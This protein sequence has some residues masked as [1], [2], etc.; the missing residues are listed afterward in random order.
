[1][2]KVKA[3]VDVLQA[4]RERRSIRSYAAQKV[5]R[6]SVEALLAAAVRAPTAV[7]EEPWAFAVVQDAAV[8]KRISDRAKPLFTEQVHRAHLDRG[9]HELHIFESPS[10]NIFYDASTLIVICAVPAGPFVQADCWL[11]AE[12]L[13]LAAWGMGLGT[14][15]V[16][17]ALPALNLAE[18]KAEIDVPAQYEAVAPIIVG[19]PRGATPISSRKA[20]RVLAWK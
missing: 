16:G 2:P 3:S 20:P 5:D 18:V 4:I 17:S 9:G 13:I 14:C 1:M 7:H 11:A 6:E 15:V 8:L 12:N 10:F 19:I